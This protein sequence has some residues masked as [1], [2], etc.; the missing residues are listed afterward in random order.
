MKHCF[1]FLSNWKTT[2]NYNN[3]LNILTDKSNDY[4]EFDVLIIALNA[5]ESKRLKY[6]KIWLFIL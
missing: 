2:A 6:H 5:W 3:L 4:V 1:F